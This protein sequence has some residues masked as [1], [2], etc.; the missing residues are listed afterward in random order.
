[1]ATRPSTLE[2][3]A[4]PVSGGREI[5][6]TQLAKSRQ[7]INRTRSLPAVPCLPRRRRCCFQR[8]QLSARTGSSDAG[9]HGPAAAGDSG[10]E[11]EFLLGASPDIARFM[12]INGGITDR[13]RHHTGN[14][15][16]A[17][18]IIGSS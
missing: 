17:R 8:R 9:L 4:F 14:G 5:G 11:T 15:I 10:Q 13:R 18:R 3:K 2:C 1:M 16:P 6:G 7:L 12:Q